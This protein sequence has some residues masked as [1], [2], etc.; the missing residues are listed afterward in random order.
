M[1]EVEIIG[2]PVYFASASSL[3]STESGHTVL[4]PDKGSVV[5]LVGL[6]GDLVRTVDDGHH[7]GVAHV[8]EGGPI[9]GRDHSYDAMQVSHLM[10]T[11]PIQAQTLGA[12]VLRRHLPQNFDQSID[13]NQAL[14]T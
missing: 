7:F 6:V 3:S 8:E 12:H 9:G 13:E 10:R 11:A 2:A 14:K 5:E 1:D 4:A